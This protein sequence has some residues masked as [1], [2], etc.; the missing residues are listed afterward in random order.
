M[1]RSDRPIR[2]S[3][4][5]AEIPAILAAMAVSTVVEIGLRTTTLPRLARFL[6]TPLAVADASRPAPA[7]SVRDSPRV[8]LPPRARRQVDATRRVLRHWPFGDTC[9]RQALVSGQRLRKLGPTLHIGVARRDGEVR[10]HAWLLI[11]G[12]V[13]DPLDAARSYTPLSTP[14][15]GALP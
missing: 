6:G 9:L 14:T 5:L 3:I 4:P 1:T 8:V 13:L 10:A 11:D 12:C 15:A 7:P 2:R